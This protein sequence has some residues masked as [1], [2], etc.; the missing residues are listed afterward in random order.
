MIEEEDV[1]RDIEGWEGFDYDFHLGTIEYHRTT[2]IGKHFLTVVFYGDLNDNNAVRI[3]KVALGGG[4]WLFEVGVTAVEEAD[5]PKFIRRV[6]EEEIPERLEA[7]IGFSETIRR[8]ENKWRC[9]ACGKES[10]DG[11]VESSFDHFITE[12]YNKTSVKSARKTA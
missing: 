10:F 3:G 9:T 7:I 5:D 1:P 4:P 8:A 6:L 2:R 12:H 11:L